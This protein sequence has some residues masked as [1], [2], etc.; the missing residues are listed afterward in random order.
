MTPRAHWARLKKVGFGNGL[1]LAE[2]AVAVTLASLAVAFVPF[3]A[4][5]RR[6]SSAQ[7]PAAPP[8]GEELL[9][10]RNGRWAV[11]AAARRLPWR[12]VCFQKGLAFH[13]MMRRRR[14]GTFLHYGVTQ[15]DEQG[16]QAHVWV[17]HGGVNYVGGE[18][19]S[20]FVCLATYP[21]EQQLQGR[22]SAR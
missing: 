6:L 15:S 18:V 1:L 3:A 7:A 19:A 16:L 14:I 20:E 8:P 4:L 11:E 17:S 13:A 10:L 5:A 9:L 21:P 22:G 2:A 12:T